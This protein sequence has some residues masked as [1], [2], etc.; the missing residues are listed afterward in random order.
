[1]C[2]FNV[3]TRDVLLILSVSMSV[4][5]RIVLGLLASALLSMFFSFF[6][7]KYFLSEELF[8]VSETEVTDRFEDVKKAHNKKMR[9]VQGSLGT[10]Y[11]AI[12]IVPMSDSKLSEVASQYFESDVYVVN[13]NGE[14]L[15]DGRRT[16]VD[17]NQRDFFSKAFDTNDVIISNPYVDLTSN[18]YYVSFIRKISESSFLLLNVPTYELINDFGGFYTIVDDDGTIIFD[19]DKEWVNKNIFN[20]R[21]VFLEAKNGELLIYNTPDGSYSAVQFF[22]VDGY[23]YVIYLWV[24]PFYDIGA[25]SSKFLLLSMVVYVF[26]ACLASFFVSKRELRNLPFIV[27]WI[28]SIE[29]GD[30]SHVEINKKNNELDILPD[31]LSRLSLRLNTTVSQFKSSIDSIDQKQ[32]DSMR[33]IE[34]NRSNSVSE[35]STVEQIATASTELSSTAK[36]VADNAQRAEKSAMEANEIILQSHSV[37]KN[38]T[39][40]TENISQSI[41]E[42]Q[43]VVNLLREHSEHISSVVDVINNISEQTNLLA[44]NAAIEAA[45]AGEQGRGFAVVADEV[46]A[47]AGKTQ[48]S[49]IDIQEIIMQLQEQ[50]KQADESMMQNVELMAVTKA[51]T[52]ELTQSFN[53]ISDKVSS[54]S[55]VNSI[56]ATAAEEQNTVTIDIS[57]QLENMRVLVQGNIDGIEDTVKASESVVEVT[58]ALSSDLSFFKVGK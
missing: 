10:F 34:T 4:I 17:F 5:K 8:N 25:F 41:S 7:Y 23:Q 44:L 32:Y 6:S 48:Q 47:L 1:M 49:T 30:L 36:N 54:I 12:S 46:R 40:T 53:A 43:V 35:L 14:V 57:N 13:R 31:S 26:L 37:L 28:E 15:I 51:A 29:R 24:E 33:L 55:E 39:D 19:G 50:S 16:D 11:D 9:D 42:T 56:V 18:K 52:D 21:P 20:M 58:K 38:S 45:R 22:G 3:T 2:L 27:K